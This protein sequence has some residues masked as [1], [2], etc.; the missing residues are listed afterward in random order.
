MTRNVLFTPNLHDTVEQKSQSKLRV[1]DPTVSQGNYKKVET[2]LG[3]HFSLT[4][5]N[6]R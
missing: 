5:V 6:H 3:Y 4:C 1:F 2:Q